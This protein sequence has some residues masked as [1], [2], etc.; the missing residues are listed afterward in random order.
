MA[1][2]P[3]QQDWY[4]IGEVAD[5]I[6]MSPSWIRET[7]LRIGLEPVRVGKG[8]TRIYREHEIKRLK[9]EARTNGPDD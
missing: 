7:E 2:N 9:G 3:V 4:S 5:L 1:A 8:K 6:A